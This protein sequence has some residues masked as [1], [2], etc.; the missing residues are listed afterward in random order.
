MLELQLCQSLLKITIKITQIKK[1]TSNLHIT[2]EHTYEQCR[3]KHTSADHGHCFHVVLG[4]QDMLHRQVNITSE[5]TE[6]LSSKTERNKAIK[7]QTVTVH[8][9]PLLNLKY[10]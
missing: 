5:E 7:A 4:A 9:H 2:T 8:T 3:S 10:D 1:N 6:H